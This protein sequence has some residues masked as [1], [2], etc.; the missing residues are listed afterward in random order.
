MRARKFSQVP[1][2]VGVVLGLMVLW[3]SAAPLSR[4]G[5]TGIGAWTQYN[6]SPGIWVA[7]TDED[8][9]V[10]CWYT[11]SSSCEDYEYGPCNGGNI[12]V[13]YCASSSQGT[14][15]PDEGPTPCWSHQQPWCND[16]FD[17]YC[18]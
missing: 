2:L 5:I 8:T 6:Y 16:V 1:L 14:T 13:A 3:G 12:S 9:C 4:A 7:A 11:Y 17:A 18:D 10:Y 15:L